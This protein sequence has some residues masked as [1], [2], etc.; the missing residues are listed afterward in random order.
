MNEIKPD[1]KTEDEWIDLGRSFEN[2]RCQIRKVGTGYQVEEG[3]DEFPV[4]YVSW[5][6]ART[7]K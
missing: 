1:Q 6:G 5:H 4:I 7:L 3:Y 2:E